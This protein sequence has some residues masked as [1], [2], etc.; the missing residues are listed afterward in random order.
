MVQTPPSQR[1][2]S[3]GRRVLR[4]SVIALILIGL[5]LLLTVLLVPG[6]T[7][8]AGPGDSSSPSTA[9]PA[10]SPNDGS[11]ATDPT[12]DDPSVSPTAPS[13]PT[14]PGTPSSAP[15]SSAP[16]SDAPTAAAPGELDEGSAKDVISLAIDTPLTSADT[17]DALDDTLADIAIEGYAAELEAQ[18]LELTSQGWSLTGSPHVESLEIITLEADSDPAT[19]QVVACIDSSEVTT[20]DAAGDPVGDPSAASPRALHHFTMIQGDDGVWRIS[21][22]SFP[23]DPSC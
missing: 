21:T 4:W 11:T 18:W 1:V 6:D 20:V 22:H 9:A 17:E 5:G 16:P 8:T 15:P 2:P 12:T 23:D 13:S 14:P 7:G 10:S 3:A 19:A